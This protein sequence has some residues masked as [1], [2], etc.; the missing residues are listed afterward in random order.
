MWYVVPTGG[1]TFVNER[2]ADY[3]DLP[4][5]HPLRFGIDSAAASDSHIALLHPE[6]H[7]ETR[8][9]WSNCFRTGF[10]DDVSFRV[11]NAHLKRCLIQ[12]NEEFGGSA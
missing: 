7:A 2:T 10:A 4:K 3:H 1:L 8:I 12:L 11:R 5:D 9:V 6:D